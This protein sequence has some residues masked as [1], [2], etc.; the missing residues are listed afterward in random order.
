MEK[1]AMGKAERGE[2]IGRILIGLLLPAVDK[3][4]DATD[5]TIQLERN[6]HVAFALAAFR[7][8]HGRFP[9]QLSELAPKYLSKVPD[10]LFSGEPLIYRPADDGYLLYSVGI[11]GQDDD[12]R[13]TDDDPK[14]DDPRIRMPVPEPP[15]K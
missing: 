8:D 12:G 2:W 11:N 13:W 5:R 6:L 14:G 4:Q 3:M 10:D 9:K 1:A 15:V 7:A